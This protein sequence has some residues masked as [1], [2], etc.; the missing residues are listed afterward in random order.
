MPK[1]LR[2]IGHE[3]RLS[4]IDHL[5]EL[6]SRLI[7]AGIFVVVIFA[8]CFWQNG[9]LLD[10]V[11]KPL[12]QVHASAS[13]LSTVTSH[14]VSERHGLVLVE[15][16]ALSLAGS[17]GLDA[18]DRAAAALIAKGAAEAVKSLPTH[19]LKDKPIT[20]GVGEPF[21]TTISVVFYFAL[22]FSLPV[23]LYQIYAFVIPA[24][25]PHEQRIAKP[26]M[27]AAPLLFAIGVLFTYF[28]VLPP[29]V[30]FLQGYNS[31]QFDSLVQ[32]APYYRFEVLTMI[33]IGLA[34]QVPLVLLALQ[35]AGIIT[36]STLTGNWRYA[37][38][39]ITVIVAALPGVD[40]V[41]MAFEMLPLVVLYLASI[42]LVKYADRRDASRARKE[43][44]GIV[45]DRT[46]DHGE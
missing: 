21:T 7:A 11:N 24:L 28:L 1:V 36:G 16:G 29:A 26:V 44:A 17:A 23:L 34:F 31:N 40:P 46:D 37:I 2:P 6:R 13:H 39:I 3:D 25:A 22:L 9:K 35:R 30:K 45:L 4:V 19:R 20:I 5:D 41:T 32:A 18:R 14:Q 10:I 43:L 15:Q 42:V 27:I 12:S 33:G 38:V 8:V